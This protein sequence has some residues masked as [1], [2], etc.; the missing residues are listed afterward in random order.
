ML[1]VAVVVAH[2]HMTILAVH[3]FSELRFSNL[4]SYKCSH[5]IACAEALPFAIAFVQA[6]A[7]AFAT[8]ALAQTAFAPAALH[9]ISFAAPAFATL[10][11]AFVEAKAFGSSGS[12]HV[13][14]AFV[15]HDVGR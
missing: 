6:K 15:S 10:A 13:L 7:L 1:R 3:T 8:R 11:L 5:G 14:N 12:L 2:W 4:A 9:E